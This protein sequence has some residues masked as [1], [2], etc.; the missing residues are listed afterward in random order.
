MSLSANIFKIGAWTGLSRV[1]GFVRDLL[2][3]NVLGAGRLS[4]IFL[5]AF[6]LPNLFRDLLGEGALS[7]VFVPMF[8]SHKN[9]NKAG[10]LFASN[11]FS[12]LM[13]ILLVITVIALV[14]MPLII[15]GIAPGFAD[16]PGKMYMTVQVSRILFLYVIL[17]CGIAFL[18]GILNAFSDFARAAMMPALLNVFMI[19]GLVLA[20]HLDAGENAIY[21]LSGAVLLSGVTQFAILWQR[22]RARRF[23]LCIVRPRVTPQIKTMV[24]RIGL[25]FVGSGFYQLNILAGTLIAS[26][27]SGAISWLYYSDRMVQLPFAVIGLAAGTVL[28]TSISDALATKDFNR[29]YDYQNKAIR[30]TMM[31]TLPCMAGLFV[32]ARPIMGLLFEHGAWTSE[33]TLAVAFAIMIQVFALPA[34]TTS[35]VF[36]RTLYAAQDVKAP[37]KISIISLII[38]IVT[39]FALVG[40]IGY[41]AVPVGTVLAGYL[42]AVWL[43]T[44]CRR[45]GLFRMQRSTNFAVFM[46]GMLSIAMGAGL[47]WAMSVGIITGIWTLALAII[48]SGCVYLPM[49]LFVDRKIG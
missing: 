9:R 14:A 19:G 49:A 20:I 40:F 7:L 3:A 29:V 48:L 11:V 42:R 26:Y 46:F 43:R 4:D 18:S 22:L 34:M 23:G 28:L 8:A 36:G 5:T 45:R 37:V 30:S 47:W 17:V 35:Q 25:G 13:A 38:G 41:L 12:W 27:Q 39:M 24:K 10:A 2:I 33:S 21:I 16:D 6:R 1:L 32:L 31:L 44:E 15:W